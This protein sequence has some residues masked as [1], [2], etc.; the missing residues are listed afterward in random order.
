MDGTATTRNQQ[1]D[2]PHETY[3]VRCAAGHT[4]RDCPCHDNAPSR[5]DRDSDALDVAAHYDR[6]PVRRR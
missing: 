5:E 6:D 1:P 3:G 4:L 2:D